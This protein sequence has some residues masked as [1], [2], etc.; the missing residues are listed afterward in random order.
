MTSL[1]NQS[2]VLTGCGWVTPF[3]ADSISDVLAA[4]R[5]PA[6]WTVP[7]ERLDDFPD[8]SNELK[9]DRGAWMTAVALEHACRSAS[10]ELKSLDSGRVGLV[11]GCGLAGQLGMIDFADEVRQQSPRFVSPIHFPQTVG[12]YIAGALAR[13]YDIRGPN[14]TLASGATSGLDAIVEACSLLA[15]G[16]ADLV[17]AGGTEQLSKALAEGLSELGAPAI[18]EASTWPETP[19]SALRYRSPSVAPTTR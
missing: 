15:C 8:L 10:V 2:I 19:R 1:P 3:A 17:F 12:N 7:D 16:S 18:G 9:H 6:C 13:G 11:L 4:A 5:Q 14:I